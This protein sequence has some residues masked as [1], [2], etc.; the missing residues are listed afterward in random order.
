MERYFFHFLWIFLG[1]KPPCCAA[2][3]VR[4]GREVVRCIFLEFRQIFFVSGSLDLCMLFA[5]VRLLVGLYVRVFV[6]SFNWDAFSSK[7]SG[8]NL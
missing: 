8:L 5:I 4:S 7:N 6:S 1:R 3:F 2:R